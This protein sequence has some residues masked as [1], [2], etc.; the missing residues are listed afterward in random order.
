MSIDF[1]LLQK[2][3]A[4]DRYLVDF[5]KIFEDS[6]PT[7]RYGI[8]EVTRANKMEVEVRASVMGYNKTSG[9]KA[10]IRKK[11]VDEDD[12]FSSHYTTIPIST[13]IEYRN[14][15]KI[16]SVSRTKP[17]GL[18]LFLISTMKSR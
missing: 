18:T 17:K 16:Y 6:D 13:L 9:P 4:Y 2:P 1:I 15:S 3:Q 8:L 7:Y 12:Y 11:K 10:D 5:S 14:T